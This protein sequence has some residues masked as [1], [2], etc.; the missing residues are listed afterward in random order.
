MEWYYLVAL[1]A[2]GTVVYLVVG[3]IGNKAVDKTENALRARRVQKQNER[4]APAQPARRLADQMTPQAAGQAR[5]TTVFP[6]PQPAAAA[7]AAQQAAPL[8]QERKARFCAAC[9]VSLAE[10]AKF[11]PMC[12]A[13]VENYRSKE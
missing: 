12:G 2:I 4:S 11:C 13:V 5:Q 7:Q 8:P 9:G 1:F 6:G 10:N 3:W